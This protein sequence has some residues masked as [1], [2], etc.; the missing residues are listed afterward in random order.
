MMVQAVTGQMARALA[1]QLSAHGYGVRFP[2]GRDPA[3]FQVTGLP[4]DPDVEV[5]AEDDGFTGCHYTGRTAAGA[6]EVIARLP[7]TRHPGTDV[8]TWDDIAVEWHYLPAAGQHASPDHVAAPL[9]AHLAV[10]GGRENAAARQHV[11][12]GKGDA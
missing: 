12:A 4:D 2:P 9:L 8:A 1:A 5:C 11:T 6:A 3:V 7:V 10:L